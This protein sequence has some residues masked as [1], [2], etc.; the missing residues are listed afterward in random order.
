MDRS[1]RINEPDRRTLAILLATL[2][3]EQN[4]L[5]EM[6]GYD[7]GYVS[8]VF[9]GFTQARPSFR[10]AFGETIGSLILGTFQP[11][12]AESYPAGPLLELI[13]SR[14]AQANNKREFYR[15]LGTNLQALKNR[16][17]FDGIFVD[18]VCCSL[19]VHPSAVYPEFSDS[20]GPDGCDRV[21]QEQDRRSA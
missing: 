12:T 8:N 10:R 20:V 18:R 15:E 11:E 13:T 6:M 21:R 5:A 17:R 19:G 7:R 14:A 1:T 9:N 2:D 16:K 3:I 4:E